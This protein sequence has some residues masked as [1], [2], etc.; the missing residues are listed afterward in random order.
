MCV[1]QVYLVLLFFGY[2]ISSECLSEEC[3]INVPY[4]GVNLGQNVVTAFM[5]IRS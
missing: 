3:E 2:W 5:K 1:A 4:D